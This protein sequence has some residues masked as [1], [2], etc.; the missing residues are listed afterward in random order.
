[1]SIENKTWVTGEVITADDLNRITPLIVEI[2]KSASG[3]TTIYTANKTFKEINDALKIGKNVLCLYSASD[4]IQDVCGMYHCTVITDKEEGYE[5][6]IMKLI[7]DE[8]SELITT[9][10]TGSTEND[11]PTSS[12]NEPT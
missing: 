4:A 11:Y 10:F 6:L 5:G 9:V 3:G 8:G 2:T 1:M 12:G 7:V